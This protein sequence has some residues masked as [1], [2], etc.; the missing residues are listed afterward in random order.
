MSEAPGPL[1]CVLVL[2]GVV[3]VATYLALH[4]FTRSE[5]YVKT[6]ESN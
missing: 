3:V 6:P 4:I 2:L 1:A 5:F